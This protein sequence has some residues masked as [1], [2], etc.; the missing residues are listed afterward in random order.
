MKIALCFSG[1][2]RSFDKGHE[3]Y[4]KNLLDHYDVDVFIHSWQ[5]DRQQ[6]L[7][8]LYKPKQ[9]RFDESLSKEESD[10]IDAKYTHSPNPKV[11]P[12]R[13]T[14]S[15]FKSMFCVQEL[16][17]MEQFLNRT[18]YDWVIRTRTDYALNIKIPFEELDNSKLYIPNCRMVPERDFGND[19][20]A[21]SSAQNMRKYMATYYNMDHYYT[22]LNTLYIGEDMMRA[23]L[24]ENNLYGENLVYVNM[25]NPFPPGPLNGTWHSLIRDDYAQWTGNLKG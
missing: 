21:F 10:R 16:L 20:F 24:R 8:D 1:Q 18:N 4:K 9:Y 19:Q 11:F 7:V 5:F 22:D 15:M 25:N 2:A 12:P 3:Y 17:A 23:N 6:E 13:F 14:Y